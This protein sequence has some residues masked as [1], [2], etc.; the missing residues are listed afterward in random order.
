MVLRNPLYSWL[1]VWV[2]SWSKRCNY[3]ACPS[4]SSNLAQAMIDAH[5]AAIPFILSWYGNASEITSKS[6]TTNS[7]IA[8]TITTTRISSSS[9][10]RRRGGG[11]SGRRNGRNSDAGSS[12]RTTNS[13]SSS[14]TSRTS[15]SR[16]T[17]GLKIIRDIHDLLQCTS[18]SFPLPDDST[19]D[20]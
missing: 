19:N 9:A 14:R 3:D 11:G 8:A 12:S 4:D 20:M 15:K 1:I 2:R 13:A 16:I 5:A 6:T 17:H 7:N 10:S 18:N